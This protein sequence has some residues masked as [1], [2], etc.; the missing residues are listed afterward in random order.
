MQRE[1]NY[2]VLKRSDVEKYLNQ[3]TIMRLNRMLNVIE[4]GRQN[5]GKGITS[6]VVVGED[7]PMYED[8]WQ[9]IEDWVDD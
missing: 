5:E 7:W 8:T 1:N 4:L 3:A 9:S 6:Y 2:L